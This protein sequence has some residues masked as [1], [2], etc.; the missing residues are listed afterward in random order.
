VS[1]SLSR[2]QAILLGI[3]VLIGLGLGGVGLFAVGSRSWFAGDSFHVRAGFKGVQ[4]VEP[5]TR[6]RVQGIDAGEVVA[7]EPPATPG[8]NVVLRMRID[9]KMRSLIRGD[10][11]VQIVGEGLIGGKVVEINPGTTGAEPVQDNAL[12]ASRPTTELTD[13]L[14]EVKTTLQSVRE[15]DGA[16]GKEVMATL[17]QTR[18]T[19]ASFEKTSDAV[20]RLPIV[21]SYAQDAQ[22]LLVRPGHERIPYVFAEADLFEPG[23]A[24]LTEPGRHRLDDLAPK[25][26]GSLMHDKAELVVVAHAD[27]KATS[28]RDAR[29]VTESQSAAVLEYLKE[30]HSVQKAGVVSWRATT[31]LGLGT[32][33]VPGE[34]KDAKLPP[35]RVEVLVFVPQK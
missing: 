12:L 9:G 20:R 4:G 30:H 28:A 25:L 35:A 23:R 10:A 34:D 15:G 11:T 24:T 19:M 32:D 17:G 1:R 22:K 16:M 3:V 21:N 27:P 7:V 31:A 18:D 13:V 8:S 5:G 29:S 6:V 14:A 2:W 26:K 33:P